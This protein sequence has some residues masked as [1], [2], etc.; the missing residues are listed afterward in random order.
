MSERRLRV[1]AAAVA[2]AV[3]VSMAAPAAAS[4]GTAELDRALDDQSDSQP[5][6]FTF[7][8]SQD[9]EVTATDSV[10]QDGGDV[11]F[12]FSGWNHIG[13]SAGTDVT[14]AVEE[15]E[16]YEVEYVATAYSGAD[17][18]SHSASVTVEHD[19]GTTEE[20]ETLWLSVDYLDPEFGFFDAPEE[21]VVFTD[22]DT[23]TVEIEV[24]VPN[25]GDGVMVLEEV[26]TAGVPGDVDVDVAST[27]DRIAGNDDGT[28]VLEVDVDP[29]IA[30]GTY[31][32][33]LE[34][35]D[36]LDNSASTDV[37]LDVNKPPVAGLADGQD[38]FRMDDVLVGETETFEFTVQEQAGFEGLSGLEAEVRSG[39]AYGEIEFGVPWGFGTDPGGTD[40]AEVTVTVDEN[41]PQHRD[42]SF[43]V[44]LSGS[45]GDSP[46]TEVE[47]V[48][49]AIYPAELGTLDVDADTFVFDEPQSAV[50][51]HT[52]TATVD[53]PNVGDLNMNVESVSASVDDPRVDASVESVDRV[54][55]QDAEQ[56]TID[57]TADPTAP[58][59]SYDLT[60]SVDTDDAGDETVTETFEVEHEVGI[61]VSDSA[62][63]FGEVTITD[64][65]SQTVDVAEE[66][67]YHEVENLEV[68]LVDGPDQWLEVTE[69]P[70][71]RL[72]PGEDA[73]LVLALEF[74]TEAEAYAEYTWVFEID[75][76]E[77]EARTVEV[78]AVA[79]LLSVEDIVTDLDDRGAGGGWQAD[80]TGDVADGL[81]SLETRLQQGETVSD[82]DIWRTLTIGQS[83]VVLVD[84]VEEASELQSADDYE[85]AQR[86]VV[87]ALVASNLLEEYVEGIDDDE[88]AATLG[89]AV[90]DA[91][92]P[93]DAVVDEQVD[94]YESIL[95]ADDA[96]ALERHYASDSLAELAELRGEDEASDAYVEEAEESLA[97]YQELTGTAVDRRQSARDAQR[98]FEADATL[99]VLGQPLVLNPA[100]IDEVSTHADGV[101]SDYDEAE[102]AFSEA[103]AG[104]EADAVAEE[105]ADVD[106][107]LTIAEYTLYGA[108]VVFF[109]GFLLLVAVEVLNA[110]TYIREV[111]EATAG[112]FLR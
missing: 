52:H 70:P 74:D 107:A 94:H 2:L 57:I 90:D 6:T 79:R 73:P 83:T 23:E 59:G 4:S 39:D 80:V 36:T 102:T 37:T 53:V 106:T 32:F 64:R 41:T 38:T 12:V 91:G 28:V 42:V 10:T 25:A 20:S 9:G 3:V 104:A 88:T 105:R 8:A 63:D 55:G 46:D 19:D 22:D 7:V 95:E 109:G 30:T 100:R 92:E 82:G 34:F 103:G 43:T 15:G 67:E 66:F 81:T 97:E 108:T 5:L 50:D 71:A 78:T 75:G 77:V 29:S 49:R 61:Q 58:E 26:S 31:S 96:T 48:T 62:V 85:A 84:A 60:V 13:G 112:D 93:V 1:L 17:E 47:F 98:A 24:D 44:A 87:S 11:E 33:D 40:T 45:D 99:T 56:L 14:W 35:E 89:G 111:N 54:Q 101:L 18:V 68:T 76:D 86:E 51:E 72:G 21:D 65:R 16:E 27:P 69:E 110:R